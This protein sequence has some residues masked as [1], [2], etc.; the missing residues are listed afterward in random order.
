MY[1]DEAP[2]KQ[3]ARAEVEL[4]GKQLAAAYPETHEGFARVEVQTFNEHFVGPKATAIFGVMIGAVGFVLLIACANVANLM[5][6]RA[7]D[8]SRDTSLRLALGAGRW[9]IVRQLLIEALTLSV[10]GSLCGLLLARACVRVYEVAGFSLFPYAHFVD[11]SMDVRVVGYLVAVCI[12]ASVLSGLAPAIRLSRLDLNTALKEGGRSVSGGRGAAVRSNLL[13]ACETALAVVLLVGAGAMIRSFLNIYTADVGVNVT[14]VMTATLN[15][16]AAAYP[17]QEAQVA[18][19]DRIEQRLTRLPSVESVAVTTRLPAGGSMA[20]PFQLEGQ[21]PVEPARRPMLS[22]LSVGPAYFHTLRATVVAGRA[23]SDTDTSASVPVVIVNQRWAQQYGAQEDAIGKR[24]RLFDG[25]AEEGW[26]TIVG[27]VSNIVQDDATRQEQGPLLYVPYGQAPARFAHVL[28]RTR[29]S[30]AG[31]AREVLQEIQSQAP[32]LSI[33]LLP[34][35]VRMG[36]GYRDN[37]LLAMLFLAFS[38]MALLLAAVGIHAM[39]AHSVGKRT[40]EIGVRMAMGGTS[41]DILLLVFKAGMIPVGAGLVAGLVASLSLM[42][43]LRSWLVDVSS[44]DPL[45]HLSGVLALV[46]AAAFGCLMPRCVPS[47]SI[48]SSRC[49]ENKDYA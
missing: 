34:L 49:A 14:N 22:A 46:L 23:F 10:P 8:R 2:A 18:F 24:V 38:V 4:I 19:F 42:P 36:Q 3:T 44:M 41:S 5:F 31:T 37:G 28:V 25:Q 15:L 29:S 7:I 47:G 39:V 16:P 35:S 30:S 1:D 11:L 32:D 6:A 33:S 27:V 26:R 12:G 13:I 48:Q 9:R 45:S 17:T 40:Q 21:P 20:V 43:L